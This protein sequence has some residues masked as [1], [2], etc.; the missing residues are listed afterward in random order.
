MRKLTTFV[1]TAGLALST[2]SG[3]NM[4]KQ[5]MGIVGG[6]LVGAAI[7]PVVFGNSAWYTIA[8][9]GAAGAFV[10]S[11]FGRGLDSTDR[12]RVSYTLNKAPDNQPYQFM[13]AEPDSNLV[14]KPT[15][16][17]KVNN[18][19]CRDFETTLQE[20]QKTIYD[21]GAACQQSNGAWKVRS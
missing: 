9:G 4:T 3:C 16:T 18:Q 6:A 11:Y 21:K 20:G 17:Y 5:D 8:G 15:H 7:A 1:A 2:L 10:G 14:V 13:R 12:S 19:V